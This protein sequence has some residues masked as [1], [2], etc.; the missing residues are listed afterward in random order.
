MPFSLNLLIF[1]NNYSIQLLQLTRQQQTMILQFSQSIVIILVI[2]QSLIES[3]Q[4][5]YLLILLNSSS[6]KPFNLLVPRSQLTHNL[7][8]FLSPFYLLSFFSLHSLLQSIN[9][10]LQPI[11]ILL[12][13]IHFI[14]QSSCFLLPTNCLLLIS[15]TILPFFN[16]LFLSISQLSQWF[17]FLFIF[18]MYTLYF[19]L[20]SIVLSK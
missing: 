14:L 8:H 20:K 18:V 2:L 12:Q 13:Y 10:L 15:F 1:F 9:L 6:F 3:L 17:S 11:L 7:L 16:S 4:Q 19:L 5:V